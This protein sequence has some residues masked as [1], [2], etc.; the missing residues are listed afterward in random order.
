[1]DLL[2]VAARRQPFCQLIP[3]HT[4]TS[5]LCAAHR[6][7]VVNGN[8]LHSESFNQ[9]SD[10]AGDHVGVVFV[11][12]IGDQRAINSINKVTQHTILLHKSSSPPLSPP[13]DQ[14]YPK[15]YTSYGTLE[16]AISLKI[17]YHSSALRCKFLS[18]ESFFFFFGRGGG[19]VSFPSPDLLPTCPDMILELIIITLVRYNWSAC[20]VP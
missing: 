11:T 10:C 9:D 12:M 16:N 2:L 6:A 1:M 18:H 8:T 19:G 4:D 3:V 14:L 15:V 17:R 7:L 5:A 13:K 20:S